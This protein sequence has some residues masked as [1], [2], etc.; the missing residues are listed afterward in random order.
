MTD[1][2]KN[3]SWNIEFTLDGI[4]TSRRHA[5]FCTVLVLGAI[6]LNTLVNL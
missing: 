5:C 1:Q 3:Y 2:C 4:A 6:A